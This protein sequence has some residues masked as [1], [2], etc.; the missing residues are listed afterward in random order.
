MKRIGLNAVHEF[1]R[2][3]IKNELRKDLRNS[4]IR[5][6]G[7]IECC[8]YLHLRGLLNSD[9]KW[10]IFAH[11]HDKR[12]GYYPDLVIYH[13]NKMVFAI[14]IKWN[15]RKIYNHDRKKLR[16]YLSGYA[17]KGYFLTVGPEADKYTKA[18]K[19]SEEKWKLFEVKVGLKFEGGKNSPR[20]SRW[21][22]QRKLFKV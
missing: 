9:R 12:T 11:K 15:R 5:R 21:K 18:N 10:R 4:W 19:R 8:T 14:E 2:G 7:D 17:S 16:K 6:E 3:R 13:E 22:K 20:Y 1:M